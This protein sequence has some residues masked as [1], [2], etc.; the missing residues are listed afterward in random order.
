MSQTE[1]DRD[2][3]LQLVDRLDQ[4][5][6]LLKARFR[7]GEEAKKQTDHA[8]ELSEAVSSKILKPEGC[9]GHPPSTG[10]SGGFFPTKYPPPDIPYHLTG[11]PESEIPQG[12]ASVIYNSMPGSDQEA[13]NRFFS[14]SDPNATISMSE[15]QKLLKE[16][17]KLHKRLIE[18]TDLKAE[19]KTLRDELAE[20]N[21]LLSMSVLKGEA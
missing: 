4:I 5:I 11:E 20:K 19:N 3:H 2:E 12:V 7:Q 16:N 15:Y 14:L 10:T 18:W 21:L 6:E 17:E 13:L 9:E 1:S 8:L